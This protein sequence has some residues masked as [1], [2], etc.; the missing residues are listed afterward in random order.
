MCKELDVGSGSI[1]RDPLLVIETE[2]GIQEPKLKYKKRLYFF[3]NWVTANHYTEMLYS[4]SHL[5]SVEVIPLEN[6]FVIPGD[7]DYVHFH[8]IQTLW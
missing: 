4:S 3:P 1:P 6:P 5:F 7:A 2:P 8:W